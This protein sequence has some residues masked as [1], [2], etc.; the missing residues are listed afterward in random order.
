MTS[1]SSSLIRLAAQMAQTQR[2]ILIGLGALGSPIADAIARIRAVVTAVL[3]DPDR[4]EAKNLSSQHV[5]LADVGHLKVAVHRRRIHRINPDLR[6]ST[7]PRRVQSVPLGVL[8]GAII[9][10]APDSRETRRFLSEVAWNLGCILVDAGIEP[11]GDLLR[12]TIYAPGASGAC[13]ACLLTGDEPLEQRYLCSANT[14]S[15]PTNARIG[16]AVAAAGHLC[17]ELG[18]LLEGAAEHALIS[19]QLVID[20]RHHRH[21]VTVLRQNAACRHPHNLPWAITHLAHTPDELTL[22]RLLTLICPNASAPTLHVPTSV[23]VSRLTCRICGGQRRLLRLASRLRPS[24]Q[25]CRACGGEM[26]AT[27]ADV[28]S[29]LNPT[30]GQTMRARPLSALGLEGADIVAVRDGDQTHYVQLGRA[31]RDI[32]HG[33]DQP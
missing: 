8:R 30:Q 10:C 6:I 26:L 21:F 25:R 7:W 5:T 15:A 28:G 32:H 19:R 29:T 2:V 24:Q 12:V 16:L 14:A 27:A 13:A 9:V 1:T 4:V 31:K 11:T 17:I 20:C 18:K 23:F 22:D 33:E 3:I